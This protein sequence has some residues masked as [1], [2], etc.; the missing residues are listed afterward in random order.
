MLLKSIIKQSY[1]IDK[2]SPSVYPFHSQFYKKTEQRKLRQRPHQA[3]DRVGR[4]PRRREEPVRSE[5][6]QLRADPRQDFNAELRS[7]RTGKRL[8]ARRKQ[9]G[10]LGGKQH[11]EGVQQRVLVAGCQRVSASF[12]RDGL[13]EGLSVRKSAAGFFSVFDRRG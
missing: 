4:L 10:V 7:V 6:E 5:A 1:F 2:Y 12:R 9:A 8:R 3:H 13:H 11:F